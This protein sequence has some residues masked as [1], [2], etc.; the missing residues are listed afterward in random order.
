VSTLNTV[1]ALTVILNIHLI[2]RERN[3]AEREQKMNKHELV[4][5]GNHALL[6][7]V[8]NLKLIWREELE[9]AK[10]MNERMTKELNDRENQLRRKQSELT[11]LKQR[12]GQGLE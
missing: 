7:P 8:R 6:S 1:N 10:I 9:Q 11:Q 2:D 4:V 5:Q 12:M 3:I